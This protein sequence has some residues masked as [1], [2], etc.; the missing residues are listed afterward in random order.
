MPGNILSTYVSSIRR[1]VRSGDDSSLSQIVVGVEDRL[2][3]GIWQNPASSSYT[4]ATDHIF[5]TDLT[6]PNLY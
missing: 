3:V 6:D 2:F 4:S 1:A 5:R